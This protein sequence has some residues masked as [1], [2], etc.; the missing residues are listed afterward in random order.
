MSQQERRYST[1]GLFSQSLDKILPQIVAP[2]LQKHGYVKARL[3]V[4]WQE[5]VG[6]EIAA[7]AI[8]NQL[9]FPPHK[10]IQGTLTLRVKTGFALEVQHL[11][12]IILEKIAIYFGYRVVERIRLEQR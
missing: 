12:N 3:M 11:E 2:A 5:I 10:R 9:V 1:T 6:I 8:P 7:K 4:H